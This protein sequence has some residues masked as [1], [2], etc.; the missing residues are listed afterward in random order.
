VFVCGDNS[1]GNILDYAA[2][3]VFAH[4]GKA[5]FKEILTKYPSSATFLVQLRSQVCS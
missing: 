1:T 3:M 2:R 5:P 4:N